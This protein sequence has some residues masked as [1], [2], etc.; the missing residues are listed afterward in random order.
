MGDDVDLV[1]RSGIEMDVA[2]AGGDRD[3]GGA[4]DVEGA[5]EVAVG[6]EGGG[7]GEGEG[8]AAVAR[9]LMVMSWDFL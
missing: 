3:V 8:A 2:G 4:A 1:A 7:G 9:T 5:V 6:G